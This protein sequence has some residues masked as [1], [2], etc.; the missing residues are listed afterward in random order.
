MFN[1]FDIK[2]QWDQ[3]TSFC[4][5]QTENK[6]LIFTLRKFKDLKT[7]GAQEVITQHSQIYGYYFGG[8]L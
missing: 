2:T 7:S 5:K 3:H 1:C 4:E 8:P 6:Q